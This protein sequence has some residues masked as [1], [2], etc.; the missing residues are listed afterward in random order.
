L[1]PV[2]NRDRRR[3]RVKEPSRGQRVS[4]LSPVARREDPSRLRHSLRD[5]A[6]MA[7]VA[8]GVPVIAYQ[9]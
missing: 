6:R 4:L 9:E 7:A 5:P 1:R 8:V 3:A 2:Q